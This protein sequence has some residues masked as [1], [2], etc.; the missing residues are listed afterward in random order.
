M[1]LELKLC[2]F[3]GNRAHLFVSENGGIRVI[4]TKCGA[5]SKTLCDHMTSQGV[6]GNATESVIKAWNK[7]VEG[8]SDE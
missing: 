8:K 7:R 6:S 5:T 4:C 1:N 3:C 2:P